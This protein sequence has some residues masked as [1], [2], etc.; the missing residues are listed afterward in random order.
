MESINRNQETFKPQDIQL[1]IRYDLPNGQYGVFTLKHM[2]GVIDEEKLL[3]HV[4]RLINLENQE[5]IIS[6]LL[7]KEGRK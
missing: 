5:E 1:E 2:F 3:N 4:G 7:T 6:T